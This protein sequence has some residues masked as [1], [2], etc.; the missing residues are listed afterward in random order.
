[1]SNLRFAVGLT[2]CRAAQSPHSKKRPLHVTTTG[3]RILSSNKAAQKAFG[4]HSP[5]SDS[6]YFA[7]VNLRQA[8]SIFSSTPPLES[9]MFLIF[10]RKSLLDEIATFDEDGCAKVK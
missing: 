1:M 4:I 7:T 9:R 5:S 2:C 6:S 10:S 3:N 8:E